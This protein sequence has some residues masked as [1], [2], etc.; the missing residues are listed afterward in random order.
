MVVSSQGMQDLQMLYV[1]NIIKCFM[2]MLIDCHTQYVLNVGPV[3]G[4][5]FEIFVSFFVFFYVLVLSEYFV[6]TSYIMEFINI[7]FESHR[8][9]MYWNKNKETLCIDMKI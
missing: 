4:L 8:K 1:P 2:F 5:H 3:H 9:D 7:N 6:H